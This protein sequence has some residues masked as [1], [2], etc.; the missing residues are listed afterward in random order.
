MPINFVSHISASALVFLHHRYVPLS[1]S[2]ASR[3]HPLRVQPFHF[4]LPQQKLHDSENGVEY[5]WT[6]KIIIKNFKIINNFSVFLVSFIS[7]CPRIF[8]G[9]RRKLFLLAMFLFL[10]T[11]PSMISAAESDIKTR[12]ERVALVQCQVWIL[13]LEVN[14]IGGADEKSP[15]IFVLL[16]LMFNAFNTFTHLINIWTCKERSY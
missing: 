14:P 2:L 6:K 3:E 8:D 16:L 12:L 11:T 1:S 9:S 4:S 15:R 13:R 5:I 10:P 7:L